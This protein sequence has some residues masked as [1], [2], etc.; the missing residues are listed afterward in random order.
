[1]VHC[2]ET[3][4]LV[5]PLHEREINHPERCEV[6]R[7]TET[8]AVTHL[9]TEYSEHILSLSLGTTEYEKHIA[10][11]GKM[12]FLEL[13]DLDRLNGLLK[14]FR[15]GTKHILEC[16]GFGEL[17]FAVDVFEEIYNI[18]V[19]L[20]EEFLFL[21][22]AV[23]LASF[24]QVDLALFESCLDG[25]VALFTV[26]YAGDVELKACDEGDLRWVSRKFLDSLPTW[27]GDKIFL[28]LLRQNVPFFSLKLVY[29]GDIL[30]YAALDGEELPCASW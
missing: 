29:Q 5:I 12:L 27:E 8:E 6:E 10:L 2:V 15:V 24:S 14:H 4:S 17:P 13:G 25:S 22:V 16:S 28:D 9:D 7:I 20:D 30:T 19:E 18:T 26:H 11:L 21:N 23:T 3:L 1:M